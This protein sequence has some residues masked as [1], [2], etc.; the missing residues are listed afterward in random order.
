LTAWED[1]LTQILTIGATFAHKA[2]MKDEHAMSDL[3]E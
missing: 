1:P 2:L 3:H